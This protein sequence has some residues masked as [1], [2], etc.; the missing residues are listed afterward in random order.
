MAYFKIQKNI[1]QKM[2]I[3]NK[4][5]QKARKKIEYGKSPC[6]KSIVLKVTNSVVHKG[7][8]LFFCIHLVIHLK[9]KKCPQGNE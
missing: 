8:V 2:K 3:K 7:H 9:Q 4:K 1:K 6:V 5:N